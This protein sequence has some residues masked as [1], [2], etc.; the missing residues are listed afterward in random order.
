[1]PVHPITSSHPHIIKMS[2]SVFREG[3]PVRWSETGRQRLRT[4]PEAWGVH[5][6]GWRDEVGE[7]IPPEGDAPLCLSVEF[8]GG[9]VW[10][11]EADCFVSAEEEDARGVGE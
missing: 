11:W 7:V 10:N 4:M 3:D 1:M 5:G 8:P 2:T 6:A 9:S